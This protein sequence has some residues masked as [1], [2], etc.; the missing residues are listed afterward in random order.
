[1]DR[2][3]ALEFLE[4]PEFATPA[5]IK[6][7]LEAKLTYYEMLS[8]KAPSAFVRRL[9]TR[10][11]A[12]VKDIMQASASWPPAAAPQM[13]E[14][15]TLPEMIEDAGPPLAFEPMVVEP[16]RPEPP[17]IKARPSVLADPEPVRE[18]PP[19]RE[20]E[21]VVAA[22]KPIVREPASTAA[23]KPAKPEL[24]GWLIRHTENQSP[25]SYPLYPGKNYIGRKEKPGF[26]P[27]VRVEEDPYIS[28]IHAVI[29]AEGKSAFFLAD[30]LAS[31]GDKPSTNGTYLNGN[32]DRVTMKTP[33]R[34]NDT[35]Q[36]GITKLMF[37]YNDSALEDILDE[38][39]GK[40]YMHTVVIHGL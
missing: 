22:A 39:A 40:D 19:V 11:V 38:V 35:I 21:P 36:I 9:H 29:I 10:N 15:V 25:V 1:M 2:K 34:N 16:E 13:T 3:E 28:K 12:R 17:V 32:E 7:K 26:S 6:A 31:I 23:V 5:E 8:E 33:L 37:R 24:V 30:D 4:L 18:K 20:P 27:F 14:L